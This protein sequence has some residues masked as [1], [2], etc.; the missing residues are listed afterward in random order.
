MDIVNQ[1]L[2]FEPWDSEKTYTPGTIFY[3]NCLD[4]EESIH[5]LLDQGFRVIIDNLWEVNIGPLRQAHRIVCDSWFWYNESLWYQ[6]QNYDQYSPVPNY[7]YRA[8]MPMNRRH[9]HRDDFVKKV[10]LS[11]LLWSYVEMGTQLPGDGDMINWG[12]QRNMNPDWYNGSYM[13]MVVET[14]VQPGSKYTPCFITGKT[15]KPLAFYHPF[16]VYGNRGTLNKLHSWGFATFDNLWDESY[17]QIVDVNVRRDTV[18]NLLGSVTIQPHD[19]ETQRRLEHNHCLFFDQ[20]KVHAG[21]IEDIIEP[22]L[23]YAE[24]R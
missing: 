1:Y 18:I 23:N 5:Q 8:L 21:I 9:P 14:Y 16:I 6:Y 22:L 4:P 20:Q 2:R 13:S 19:A 7:H 12:T 11:D 10:D 17:D 24:T 15:V 3:A